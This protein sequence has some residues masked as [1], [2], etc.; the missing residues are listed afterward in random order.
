MIAKFVLL[1]KISWV[2]YY[3]SMKLVL[4]GLKQ[5]NKVTREKKNKLFAM[6]I[7]TL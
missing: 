6:V 2:S 4:Y 1:V 3:T 7:I 5:V